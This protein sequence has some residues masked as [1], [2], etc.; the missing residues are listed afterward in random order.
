MRARQ[1]AAVLVPGTSTRHHSL[2]PGTPVT[3]GPPTDSS[4]TCVTKQDSHTDRRSQTNTAVPKRTI[5]DIYRYQYFVPGKSSSHVSHERSRL[6]SFLSFSRHRRARHDRPS[7]SR[8]R[9]YIRTL[10]MVERGRG[11]GPAFSSAIPRKWLP[12]PLAI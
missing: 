11:T 1:A 6:L 9:E 2:A 5:A 4:S 12:W 8:T 7:R 10:F 3:D